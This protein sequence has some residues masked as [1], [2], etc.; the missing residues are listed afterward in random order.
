M[1][2][3]LLFSLKYLSQPLLF[4]NKK[5]FFP[6]S[7]DSSIFV[8]IDVKTAENLTPLLFQICFFV[9][10]FLYKFYQNVCNIDFFLL[11]WSNHKLNNHEIKSKLCKVVYDQK[12][13]KKRNLHIRIFFGWR[14]SGNILHILLMSC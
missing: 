8:S 6:Q 7:L 13:T 14:S 2:F 12:L 1:M 10:F 3:Q 5:G 9:F 4:S 11:E